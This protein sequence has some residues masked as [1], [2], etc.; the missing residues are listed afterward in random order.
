MNLVE[1]P[2][3]GAW[4]R[5]FTVAAPLDWSDP[6]GESIELFVREFTDPERRHDDLPLLT[7]LQ[8]GPG[9]A[10]PRPAPVGGW[11]SEALP[12][13]RVVL[14]DQRG[15]G[16]STPVDGT[17][18]AGFSDARAAAD[19]LLHFRADSIVRDLEHVRTRCYDGKRWATLGQSFGGWITLTYLSHAPE[20]LTA[21]Y[22]CG[23]IPGTPPDPDEV[24]RRT[25]D[26]VAGKTADFY[27]RYPQ[28]VA[29]V[30]AI[31]D[32]LA[33]GD[34]TLPDGSPLSVRR[35]QTLGGDLGFGAGHQ[36]LHWL[37]SEAIRRDGRPDGEFLE[38]VLVK[39]SNARNP[40][41]WTLQESIYG[42]GA[43]GPFRWSAQRERDR[44]PEFAEDR[45]PLLFTSEMTFPW[46][47]EE[48]RALRPFAPAMA[49]LAEQKVWSPLYDPA[50][51]AAN[52]VPLAA[53]VYADD[54]F[55]D[56]GLQC[57]TLTRVGNAQT[58]VTNEYEHDGITDGRVFRRL[59]EMVRDRGGEK[60]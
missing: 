3:P 37:V 5:E 54:V 2:L 1:Y 22:V 27:R 33:A 44:R 18:I 32:R 57:D 51:L 42:D 53:A 45:R 31:A 15:T 7:Y 11:L 28:D 41:F 38:T 4:V 55:V 8:G 50:R 21:C 36:G 9:G 26:R 46:M 60:R 35:F 23:G 34:V 43:N 39:T 40:L 10:N 6:G 20:A 47:F 19:H 49:E 14:V 52:D 25:F 13:Y 58:W 17:D 56:A 12:H 29:A 59:R 24:Y 16:R 48:I 30:A